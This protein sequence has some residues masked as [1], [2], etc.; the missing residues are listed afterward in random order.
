MPGA[1]LVCPLAFPWLRFFFI[2]LL[3]FLWCRVFLYFVSSGFR[4]VTDSFVTRLQIMTDTL[5][6]Q[7]QHSY[8]YRI[9]ASSLRECG[10]IVYQNRKSEEMAIQQWRTNAQG[11]SE[12]EYSL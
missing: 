9:F 6:S 4:P 11:K 3:D 1:A 5:R 12:R 7:E 8:I 10:G 2:L